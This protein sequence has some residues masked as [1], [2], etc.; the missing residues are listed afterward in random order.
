M[1]LFLHLLFHF[2]LSQV[3]PWII[4]DYSSSSLDFKNPNTFRDL[5]SPL[6]ALNKER[7]DYFIERYNS[8]EPDS[9][10]GPPFFYG[11]HYS[12]EAFVVYYMLRQEPF[13]TLGVNLQSGRFDCPDRLF[14]D[15]RRT[16]EG[17]S[18]L[19]VS[20]VKELIP[21]FFC[22][23]EFLVNSNKLPLGELQEGGKVSD[24]VLPPWAS[25][26]VDFIRIH[27]E[28]LESDYV[29]D[30]IHEW[31]DL[32]FGFKQRG[33]AAITA[34]NVFHHITYENPG[35][36]DKIEDPSQRAAVEVF[37]L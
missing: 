32:I 29:S 5:S 4:Q 13:T 9:P 27:R 33:P 37:L 19:S 28:A 25:N 7:L 16:W 14:F 20:D 15:I 26:A 12:T 2:F 8:F 36:L 22:C 18:R 24:V 35:I 23:P 6:G 17:C 3:F 34:K 11:S 31:I 1:Y 10:M 21:E 30:H